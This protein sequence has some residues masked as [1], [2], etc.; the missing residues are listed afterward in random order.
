MHDN[1]R[2]PT[3]FT[4]FTGKDIMTQPSNNFS[5]LLKPRLPVDYPEELETSFEQDM[6]ESLS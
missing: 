1:S 6:G 2:N 3:D 5:S 4:Q